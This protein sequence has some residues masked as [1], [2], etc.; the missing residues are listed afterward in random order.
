[1]EMQ[2]DWSDPI[3]AEVAAFQTPVEAE[4]AP[5]RGRG[6]RLGG[7]EKKRD[8]PAALAAMVEEQKAA[9]EEAAEA[10]RV[11]ALV[12]LPPATWREIQGRAA[13]LDI[14]VEVVDDG[15]RL[16]VTM[17][18][19]DVAASA[20]VSAPGWTKAAAGAESASVKS[21]SATG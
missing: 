9:E 16:R 4:A 10:A 11:A 21:A 19:T 3:T 17:P 1:L 13:S 14:A 12:T 20:P 7:G 15:S 5:K 2:L 8:I 18:L 6:F